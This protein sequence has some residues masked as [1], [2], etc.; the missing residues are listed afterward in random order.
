MTDEMLALYVCAASGVILALLAR[1]VRSYF[2]RF[3]P[4][5]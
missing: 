1:F 4:S 5:D 2:E 3:L